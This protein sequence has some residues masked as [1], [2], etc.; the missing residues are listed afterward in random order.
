MPNEQWIGTL[1]EKKKMDCG[2]FPTTKT[3]PNPRQ[4]VRLR[5]CLWGF[6]Q[7]TYDKSGRFSLKNRGCNCEL[8]LNKQIIERFMSLRHL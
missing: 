6:V 4:S 1:F 8:F 7:H 2:E 5:V 3:N